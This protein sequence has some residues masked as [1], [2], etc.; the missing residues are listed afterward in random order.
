MVPL[1]PKL[2]VDLH[3]LVPKLLTVLV[4]HRQI[5]KKKT[6]LTW[7]ARLVRKL[8]DRKNHFV[9]RVLE[10]ESLAKSPVL[11]LLSLLGVLK[12]RMI[13]GAVDTLQLPDRH[14]PGH[15]ALIAVPLRVELEASHFAALIPNGRKEPKRKGFVPRA[16]NR[17]AIRKRTLSRSRS[18]H[19]ISAVRRS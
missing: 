10:L 4:R 9:G 7:K 6:L 3:G 5:P 12:K 11:E 18:Q 16:V 14:L 17:K 13:I 19:C 2:R 1:P 15:H 8:K